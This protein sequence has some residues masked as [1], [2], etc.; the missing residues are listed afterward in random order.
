MKCNTCGSH[1]FFTDR[2]PL[3]NGTAEARQNR[4]A[5]LLLAPLE[6]GPV[7][8]NGYYLYALLALNLSFF[9]ILINLITYRLGFLPFVWSQYVTGGLL[10]AGLLLRIPFSKRQRVLVL[11]RRAL[12]AGLA[13]GAITQIV[14]WKTQNFVFLATVVPVVLIVLDVFC[15]VCFL[16]KCATP[17]SFFATLLLNTGV[18]LVP[19]ILAYRL[20]FSAASVILIDLAFGISVLAAA[21]LALLK[22]LALLY[23]WRK[24]S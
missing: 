3:C 11:V 16:L 8:L 19:F 4:M 17:F 2:C 20:P 24:G 1:Y 21:N 7:V 9:C 22:L 23:R 10:A 14:L 12:Y 6:I 13:A 5:K 18:S 15:V